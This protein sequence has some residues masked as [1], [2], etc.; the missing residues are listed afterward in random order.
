MA[1]SILRAAVRRLP[2]VLSAP[3]VPIRPLSRSAVPARIAAPGACLNHDETEPATVMTI[4][5][6]QLRWRHGL[7]GDVRGRWL[8]WAR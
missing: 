7:A 4:V 2:V 5:S 6:R 3:S 8:T 1:F